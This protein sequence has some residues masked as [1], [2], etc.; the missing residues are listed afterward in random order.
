MADYD[1]MNE[2]GAET[3]EIGT[4]ETQAPYAPAQPQQRQ[5]YG[6]SGYDAYSE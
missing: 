1:D 3:P 6:G 2:R 4:P 5:P